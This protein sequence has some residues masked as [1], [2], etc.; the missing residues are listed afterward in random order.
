MPLCRFLWEASI[1]VIHWNPTVASSQLM[2][3]LVF[4]QEEL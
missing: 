3:W 1:F 4:E 2:Q